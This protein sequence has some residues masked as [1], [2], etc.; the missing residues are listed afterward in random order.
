[1]RGTFDTSFNLPMCLPRAITRKRRFRF[2]R[3]R[4]KRHRSSLA[5][6]TVAYLW[7]V[8]NP[9]R[10]RLLTPATRQQW[11]LNTGSTI[12]DYS[13]HAG[14]IASIAFRPTAAP[15][16][17][18]A[19][20]DV[21]MVEGEASRRVKTDEAGDTPASESSS[22]GVAASLVKPAD[23][24]A[25]DGGS[26]ADADGEEI[27]DEAFAAAPTGDVK[28]PPTIGS[29]LISKADSIKHVPMVGA[30]GEEL[31]QL[32]GDVFLSTSVHD[33]QVM[34]WDRRIKSGAKG[35]VRRLNIGG[36]HGSWALSVRWFS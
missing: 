21:A 14:Q 8:S 5:A 3:S 13:A 27:D 19:P 16:S 35:G 15:P 9:S 29:A 33:G 2:S 23:T 32:S 20:G 11:D 36:K 34:I 28:P 12:R 17:S 22:H 6:G 24:T 30:A 18:T 31:P 26:E 4:T 25:D 10:Q 1:M 7:V